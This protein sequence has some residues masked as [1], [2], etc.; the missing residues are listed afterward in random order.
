[1]AAVDQMRERIDM[2]RED[3]HSLARELHFLDAFFGA[4]HFRLSEPLPRLQAPAFPGCDFPE[5]PALPQLARTGALPEVR[6][7]RAADAREVRVES[8]GLKQRLQARSDALQA[9]SPPKKRP[10]RDDLL[11]DRLIGK[12]IRDSGIEEQVARLR[13]Q[14][15]AALADPAPSPQMRQPATISC[16]E[17]RQLPGR[18]AGLLG[19]ALSDALMKEASEALRA[20]AASRPQRM[21]FSGYFA[22]KLLALEQD[23]L[24]ELEPWPAPDSRRLCRLTLKLE[25]LE[26]LGGLEPQLARPAQLLE[27]SMCDL[28]RLLPAPQARLGPL[29][30]SLL[31]LAVSNSRLSAYG[32]LA[33]FPHLVQLALEHSPLRQVCPLESRKLLEL[34]LCNNQISKLEHLALLPNLKVLRLSGN[35]IQRIEGL[36]G[37][38]FLE[39]LDLSRNRLAALEGLR[40]NPLLRS[41]VLFGNAIAQAE[42][43]TALCL[44]ELVLSE[45]RLTCLAL[46]L[47]APCLLRLSLR[48]NLLSEL[49]PRKAVHAPNLEYL[50]I[51]YNKLR[52]ADAASLCA[53]FPKLKAL[54]CVLDCE[55][56]T[57][58]LIGT[59]EAS[60]LQL[61][62]I[63]GKPLARRRAPPPQACTEPLYPALER[64]FL[65]TR[66]IEEG[67]NGFNFRA[68]P[69][70]A[71]VQAACDK[72]LKVAHDPLKAAVLGFFRQARLGQPAKANLADLFASRAST[73]RAFAKAV[74]RVVR[75]LRR[76]VCRWRARRAHFL[77]HLPQIVRIQKRVRGMQSRKRWSHRREPLWVH[78]GHLRQVVRAQSLIRGFITRRRFKKYFSRVKF[79][80]DE[81]F[82]MDGL[83]DGLFDQIAIPQK[84]ELEI[85]EAVLRLLQSNSLARAAEAPPEPGTPRR[86][87]PQ[88]GLR[89]L[90]AK[91]PPPAQARQPVP[92]PRQPQKPGL[93]PV[94]PLPPPQHVPGARDEDADD[95]RSIKSSSSKMFG[96]QTSSAVS[97]SGRDEDGSRSVLSME[98]AGNS[99]RHNRSKLPVAPI[100]QPVRGPDKKTLEVIEEW[101]FKDENVKKALEFRIN[102]ERNRKKKIQK[103]TS[104]ERFVNFV[105]KNNKPAFE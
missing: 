30:D 33:H 39:R 37:C 31:E 69:D 8:A 84:A 50:N 5:E 16:L 81:D 49:D 79:E 38:P 58:A 36:E 11:G 63:N 96:L 21:Y 46:D 43:L 87:D 40:G 23:P 88:A 45:N 99:L 42:P 52:E 29:A 13:A 86:A 104:E 47:F 101:G 17:S 64:L 10:A 9:A 57:R 97:S 77:A 35:F 85:P 66:V 53:S 92:Q 62:S 32:E 102:K 72:F 7:F 80:P 3:E 93:P 61:R 4:R 59:L 100:D 28:Q 2:E 44:Q 90:A 76:Y 19:G 24:Q 67:R 41:L 103:L 55:Q 12:A 71:K 70:I 51:S 65:N 91:L 68:D 75:L 73:E 18:I 94:K 22:K 34:S 89:Q 1:M 60:S 74:E 54:D 98:T 15:A 26:S 83:E 78:R 14:Q 25:P 105:K 20:E 95:S 27:L 82:G 56:R 48:G 6:P